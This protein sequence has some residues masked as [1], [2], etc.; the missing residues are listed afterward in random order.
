M[1]KKLLF[2]VNPISGKGAVKNKLLEI[3]D[4]FIKDEW[5][6]SIHLTQEKE[7]ACNII[8]KSAHK[9]DMLVI[10]GGDGTLNEA[11]RGIMEIPSE[12][13]PKLGYIPMGTTNDFA[14][15]LKIPKNPIT[16]AKNI[17][18]GTEYKYDIGSFNNKNFTYVSAFGAFTDVAYKTPQQNKNL[19]GQTAYFL[20]GIKKIH[21]LKSYRMKVIHDGI[22]LEDEFIFGMVSNTNYLGGFKAEKAFKAQLN[23]GLF[24][25]ILI[26]RP[27]SLLEVQD[28]IAHLVI[29][30]YNTEAFVVFSTDRI[31]FETED[32]VPWTL[33]GEFGG[34]EKEIDINV[35]KQAITMYLK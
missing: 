15:N 30:E 4:V 8:R 28:L 22:E 32:A 34:D 23:D 19:L 18:K 16:A 17:V 20:E 7:D 14:A 29:Q 3:L 24:E 6:V 27:K 1:S 9:F 21:T 5:I 13:R 11:I 26:R 33:D 2:V 31:R 12:K 35:E 25:V 10:S